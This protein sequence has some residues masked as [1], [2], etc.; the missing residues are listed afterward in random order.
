MT[1]EKG[2]I[3]LYDTTLRDGT[4]QEGISLTLKDKLD[5]TKK[6]DQ[7]GIDIIEGGWPFSNPKDEEYFQAVTSLDLKNARISAFGSTRRVGTTAEEDLNLQALLDSKAEILMVVGK[8]WDLHVTQVLETSLAE[9]KSM[10]FDSIKYLKTF[11]KEVHFDAEHFFDGHEANPNYALECLQ[12]AVDAGVDGIHLCDTNGGML[13]NKLASIIDIVRDKIDTPLGIHVHNDGDLAVAN[14]ITAVEHGVVYVQG[15]INGYGERCGNAN[16]CS[17]I[18]ALQVKMG[19]QTILPEQLENL[20][21]VA[22]E[23]SELVNIGMH[24]SQPYVG[25]RAFTHKAGLHA[26]AVAKV[27]RSYE[28]MDP[29]I[30]GNSRRIVVSELAGRS[31][32]VSAAKRMGISI[33]TTE[34]KKILESVKNAEAQGFLFDGADA[35][36]EMLVRRNLGD[37]S[38]PFILED[39]IVLAEKLRRPPV[40][41]RDKKSDD[42]L[43]EAMVKV[44]I[45]EEVYHTAAEGNGPVNALDEALRKALRDHFPAIDTIRLIDYKVRILNEEGA[46]SAAVRVLIESSDGEE[47]WSTVGSST[48]IIYAS[49]LALVDSIEY[50][51]LKTK[52]K[53]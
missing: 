21:S 50:W 7:I 12:A 29:K 43:S 49:W 5:I 2:A 17:I 4:Q 41:N 24:P 36:L 30:V 37:Y 26:S 10:I 42:L 19:L 51:M 33:S 25:S 35:S 23:I 14:S 40:Q 1:L 48:N 13:P 9:N 15:T 11:D 32:I 16:L 6:L 8:T 45:G 39:F 47:N 31:N 52:S 3:I 34:T 53:K 44:R 28:H 46:T 22:Q 38:A 27:E 18:P 20:R